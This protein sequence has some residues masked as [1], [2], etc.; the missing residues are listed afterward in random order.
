MR[1][2]WGRTAVA[3]VALALLLALI[4]LPAQAAVFPTCPAGPAT[5]ASGVARFWTSDR[6]CYESPWFAGAH[7]VMIPYGCTK[8]PYY[9]P[10]PRCSGGRG[11]HHGIDI[12]MPVG[13]KVFTNVSGTVVTGTLGSAYGPHA[14]L[15]RTATRDYV[16]GHVGTVYVRDGQHVTRGQLV[17]RSNQLGAPDGPHLHVEVR[18]RGGTY[19][20]AVD[21]TA[22]LHLAEAYL[23]PTGCC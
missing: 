16:L 10:S 8:A 1:S 11:F 17:A 5:T 2:T 12:D 19:G 21:P 9:A 3:A 6:T 4:T 22:A 18:P 7:R 23:G 15:I 13:T 20:Q 14:F